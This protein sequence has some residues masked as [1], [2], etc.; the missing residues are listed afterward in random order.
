MSE[1][2]LIMERWEKYIVEEDPPTPDAAEQGNILTK[3]IKNVSSF[4]ATKWGQ[5]DDYLKDDYCKKKFPE[6]LS[7]QGGD[8]E[9]F[10]DLVA[11][12]KCTVEY[13][14]KKEVLSVLVNLL[15]GVAS[16]KDIFDKSQDVAGFILAM[17]QVEDSAR[18][19]GNLG[20]LDM[21]DHVAA[22]LDNKVENLFVKDLITV[23][24]QYQSIDDP[25]PEN[26]DVTDAL[27][28]FLQKK[29]NTRTVTGYETEG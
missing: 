2:K 26:W 3:G 12:L 16:A 25:I 19:Q 28:A 11:L 27:K 14:N 1:M 29:Y 13:Q 6:L 21:D 18:P 8:I 20:K 24:Q 7:G 9:T 15:P 10:G 5:M 22:I 23:I 17:Y 4:I